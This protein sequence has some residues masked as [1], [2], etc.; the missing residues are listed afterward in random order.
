MKGIS[1]V[2]ATILMLMITIALAG[3]AYLYISGTFTQQTGVVLELQDA[4]CTSTQI[5]MQVA[6]R[7]TSTSPQLT[8]SATVPAGGSAGGSINIASIDGAS[9]ATCSITR[10]TGPTG[11]YSVSISGNGVRTVRGNVICSTAV[12]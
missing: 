10:T 6:N 5:Q 2:I 11:S 9:S 3:T 4:T 1:T 8:C 12:A 7:G